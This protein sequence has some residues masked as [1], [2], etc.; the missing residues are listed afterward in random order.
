MTTPPRGDAAQVD[1]P[2]KNRQKKPGVPNVVPV[3]VPGGTNDWQS[4]S[5]ESTVPSPSLSIWSAQGAEPGDPSPVWAAAGT[6]SKA[7]ANSPTTV[8]RTSPRIA[9]FNP[10]RKTSR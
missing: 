10:L 3:I 9:M 1:V 5:A 6:A 8:A 2:G 7:V 4:V